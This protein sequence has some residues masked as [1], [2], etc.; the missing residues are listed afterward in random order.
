MHYLRCNKLSEASVPAR[1]DEV[2]VAGERDIQ[3]LHD[4]Y[5]RPDSGG[6]PPDF[7]MAEI[8][9]DFSRGINSVVVVG[10]DRTKRIVSVAKIARENARAGTIVAVVTDSQ[11]RRKGY[12]SA[13]VYRLVQSLIGRGKEALLGSLPE[14]HHLE[15][16]YGR[17]GFEHLLTMHTLVKTVD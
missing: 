12:A 1:L 14:E 9:D 15:R 4:L 2:Q 11:F 16:L 10:D 3:D 5:S 13:C 17:L 8:Q 7:I 6:P